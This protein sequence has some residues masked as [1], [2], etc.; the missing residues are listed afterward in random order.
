MSDQ[1]LDKAKRR[2]IGRYTEWVK[3]FDVDEYTQHPPMIEKLYEEKQLAAI[4]VLELEQKVEE[5]STALHNQELDNQKLSIL[6]DEKQARILDLCELE[7]ENDE[8]TTTSR[9]S[10]LENQRLKMQ[11]AESR[12]LSFAGFGLSL[13]AT[14]LAGI[15]VNLATDQPQ[16]MPGWTMIGAAVVLE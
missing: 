16:E 9:N 7:Q 6:I 5:L 14:L 12:R 11:L 1:I 13:V 4:T 2:I 3:K 10:E 15:G 8:L